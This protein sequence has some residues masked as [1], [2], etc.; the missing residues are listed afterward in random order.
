MS[1][2]LSPLSRPARAAPPQRQACALP[3]INS[4]TH[5]RQSVASRAHSTY[6]HTSTSHTPHTHTSGPPQRTRHVDRHRGAYRLARCTSLQPGT[7][8]PGRTGPPATT[9]CSR[10]HDGGSSPAASTTQRASSSKSIQASIMIHQARVM[11]H[12]A[13]IMTHQAGVML[14]WGSLRRLPCSASS[15]ATWPS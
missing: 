7:W 8:Q 10:A 13:G 11:I 12:L 2:A 9:A 1:S 3:T 6:R 15:W 4:G 14:S 5:A